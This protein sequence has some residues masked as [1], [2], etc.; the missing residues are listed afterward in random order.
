M[1]YVKCPK[2]NNANQ[3]TAN[4][5]NRCGFPL[6]EIT[7]AECPYCGNDIPA[8]SQFCPVCGKELQQKP[9][10]AISTIS[11]VDEDGTENTAVATKKADKEH[12]LWDD[13]ETEQASRGETSGNVRNWLLCIL[14]VLA[15]I[16]IGCLYLYNAKQT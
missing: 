14:I 5:C 1:A 10:Q 2:C 6:R 9:N 12:D 11:F 16:G 13:E 7:V 3:E 4:F 8:D 15:A